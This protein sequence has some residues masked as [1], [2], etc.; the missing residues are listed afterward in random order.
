MLLRRITNH[1]KEQNWFAVGIDFVI[2][3]IGVFIG[4]QVANWNDAR[5]QK[6]LHDDAF[7]RVVGEMHTNLRL[8]NFIR[9]GVRVELPIVQKA[10]EDLQA[11]HDDDGAL[12][13]IE[14]AL[15]PLNNPYIQLIQYE[16]LEQYL[17][18]E[19]F[20]QFQAQHDRTIM[21]E[22]LRGLQYLKSN[23]DLQAETMLTQLRGM[24]EVLR[25][26]RLNYES[27]DEY[28]E[29]YVGKNYLSRESLRE[30]VLAV[31]LSEA[32]VDQGFLNGFFTWERQAFDLAYNAAALSNRI[33]VALEALGRP[34][35]NSE[36]V[37]Q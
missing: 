26:G 1:V 18:N 36:E 34:V 16:A 30:P 37:E 7:E 33:H 20:L 8:Q 25:P 14:A 31:S 28:A 19:E 23:G 17:G 9:E 27:L 4:I 13:N 21:V 29:K 15:I 10:I 11:C 24:G 22:L 3:V 32:C 6:R 5:E 12:E 35:E 2:V